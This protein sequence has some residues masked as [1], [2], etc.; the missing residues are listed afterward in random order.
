[1]R[2]ELSAKMPEIFTCRIIDLHHAGFARPERL[3][4]RGDSFTFRQARSRLGNIRS[5]G[6]PRQIFF[7]WMAAQSR[8]FLLPPFLK[9]NA[10]AQRTARLTVRLATKRTDSVA[11]K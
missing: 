9:W 3:A 10:S 5:G 11:E 4:T 1:M 2:T 8:Q 7:E 6:T